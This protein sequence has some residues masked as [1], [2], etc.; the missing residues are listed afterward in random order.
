MILIDA[1]GSDKVRWNVINAWPTKYSA[2]GLNAA[3]SDVM[4][5]TLELAMD[6]IS[7]VK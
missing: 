2:T 6:Y 5:E 7:R 1:D 4:V 3:T